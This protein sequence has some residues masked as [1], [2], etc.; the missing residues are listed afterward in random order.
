MTETS[1]DLFPR[2]PHVTTSTVSDL[3]AYGEIIDV[4]TGERTSL[5]GATNTT[6]AAWRVALDDLAQLARRMRDQVDT[7]L[8][9]RTSEVGGSI[10]TEYGTVKQVVS[11]G[12]VSGA[13]AQ[14]I[15]AI[16]EQAARMGDIPADAV[17]NVAPLTPHVTPSR[18]ARW[19]H[20]NRSRLGEREYAE[21]VAA[22]PTEKRTV[23]V[24]P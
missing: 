1:P 13:A 14:T 22:L 17:D 21:L 5:V 2:F 12:S 16:L 15:R 18:V 20:D 10:R 11:R 7:E 23:R 24:E 4:D 8:V 9:T 6:L 19:A 3:A